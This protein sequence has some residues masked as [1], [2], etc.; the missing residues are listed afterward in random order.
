VLKILPVLFHQG[1]AKGCKR[2]SELR[3]QFGANEVFYR[4]F[5]FALRVDVDL[6]LAGMSVPRLA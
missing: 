4:L 3:N 1:W 5:F 6:K 2:F